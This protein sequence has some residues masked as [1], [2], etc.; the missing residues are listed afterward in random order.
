MLLQQL[1]LP[2]VISIV[3]YLVAVRAIVLTVQR[4]DNATLIYNSKFLRLSSGIGLFL[5]VLFLL[6]PAYQ[7]LTI[8]TAPVAYVS[9]IF[10]LIPGFFFVGLAWLPNK[11]KPPWMI[12]RCDFT[13]RKLKLFTIGNLKLDNILSPISSKLSTLKLFILLILLPYSLFVL[14]LLLNVGRVETT[15]EINV[16]IPLL[17]KSGFFAP[18]V[19]EVFWR[20][21]TLTLWGVRGLTIGTLI[22][23]AI[24][25]IQLALLGI[26]IWKITLITLVW[27]WGIPFYIKLW[28]GR[29][30]WFSFFAHSFIN[31]LIILSSLF[32]TP[33]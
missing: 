6:F 10:L 9:N 21:F 20:W 19:E 5:F 18:L 23:F 25:P 12:E 16:L 15:P 1:I 26:P 13:Y 27:F 7:Y 2:L 31:L 30:Y 28:R 29:Y 17:T 33:T 3:V 4:F 14:V 8:N 24:H 32:G 22:W 11:P